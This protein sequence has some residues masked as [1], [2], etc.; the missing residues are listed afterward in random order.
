MTQCDF[1][2][3]SW[4]RRSSE[5]RS[6]CPGRAGGVGTGDG[7]R[8]EPCRPAGNGAA[9]GVRS[10]EGVSRRADC[11]VFFARAAAF[12]PTSHRGPPLKPYMPAS[13]ATKRNGPPIHSDPRARMHTRARARELVARGSSA[14]RAPTGAQ[15]SPTHR[16]RPVSARPP[17][18]PTTS[19][20]ACRAPTNARIPSYKTWL[21][22]TSST[23][24]F[25]AVDEVRPA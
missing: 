6:A 12:P 18:P 5:A 14:G 4:R 19:A 7:D 13:L 16:R 17:P 8:V 10:W 3:G 15:K 25:L 22:P 2:Q 1:L 20:C 24:S 11:S 21:P 23:A 9:H